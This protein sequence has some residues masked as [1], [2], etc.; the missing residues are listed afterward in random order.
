MIAVLAM[1]ALV[2]APPLAAQQTGTVT[3]RVVE[4][5]SLAPISSAQVYLQGTSIGTL[6]GENGRFLILNVEAGQHTLVVERIG[7]QTVTQAISVQA[8]QS[9]TVN[10]EME[11]EVLGLDELV[12]TGEAGA[13]RRR[14]VGNTIAQINLNDVA[15]PAVNME[16]LLQGRATGISITEASGSAGSGAQIRLRGN[17]SVSQS[18]QPLI[19]V[20]GIRMRSDPYPKNVPP[21]GYSGRSANISPS[22][23]NDIDPASIERIEV[24]KGA[25]ATTLYGTEASAGVIQIFT[26]KGTRGDAQWTAQVDQGFNWLKSFG[27]DSA[28]F[29]RLD[30]WLRGAPSIFGGG[31]SDAWKNE[32]GDDF[33]DIG[34]QGTAWRQKYYLS[35]RGGLETMN[36][37]VSGSWEDNEGVFPEDREE[38]MNLRGNFT[39]TPLEDLTVQW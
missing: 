23:L 24:I 1:T 15:E 3:G 32:F 19:Y 10:I 31:I 29:M 20:D 14:E 13:A 16:S 7:Y 33:P 26:K 27:P 8:G 34:Y 5:A 36:Y 28:P 11:Q 12:V 30:P 4:S 37:F 9:T 39:F 2:A 6:T 35:V 22:P 25:A 17:V 18:N 38:K 21:V